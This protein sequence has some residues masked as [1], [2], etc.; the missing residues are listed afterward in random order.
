MP[1][2]KD[3]RNAQGS[4]SIRQ[5][6]DG[7]W[8]ARYTVGRDPGT[9]KQIRKSVYGKT[10][11]EVRKKLNAVTAAIDNGTYIEPSKLKVADWLGIWLDE[12]TLDIK[13]RSLESYQQLVK[14]HIIPALG[15]VRLTALK[16]H[17]IQKLY[18][19]LSKTHSSK[20]IKN[21]HG[22][23]HKGL[24]QALELGYI[25]VNP[26]DACKTPKTT[27]TAIKP[28]DKAEIPA[29]LEAIKGDPFEQLYTVDLFTGLRESEIIGLTWD[30][31][32]FDKGTIYIY[33]QWQKLK[34]GYQFVPPK[35]SKSRTVTPANYVLDVLKD[36]RIKQTENR[37][38]VGSA[39]DN[40]NNFIFTNELGQPVNHVTL[41]KHLKKAAC[42]IG[43]P[44]FRFHDLRHT[45]AVMSLQAGD[46]IK[47]VQEN[48]GHHSAAFTLDIYGH[49]TDTMRKE[50]A[51]RMDAFISSI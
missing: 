11:A 21:L 49:V 4:G 32:D 5:R 46:D 18:N 50:S 22:V 8:E 39:W 42:S 10:Q 26:S 36:V 47:T 2:K 29:F 35:N 38:Q 23:L 17:H 40:P 34:S 28:L 31:I 6:P 1:R 51:R 7:R 44:E 27:K 33:R 25:P 14:N 12:Y 45:Y 43:L 30:C 15:N 41:L 9:G 37:L 20:T 48:L 3:T 24:K 13:P 19:D 16:P